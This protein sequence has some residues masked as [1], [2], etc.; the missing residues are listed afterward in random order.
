MVTIQGHTLSH[1][2]PHNVNNLTTIYIIHVMMQKK[3]N[4]MKYT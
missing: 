1:H 4:T 3:L 2:N